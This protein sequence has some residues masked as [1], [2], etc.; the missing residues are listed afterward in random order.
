MKTTTNITL[1]ISDRDAEKW[2]FVVLGG[3]NES[4]S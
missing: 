3:E 4:N 2:G 1:L